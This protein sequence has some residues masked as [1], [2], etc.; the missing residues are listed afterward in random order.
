MKKVLVVVDMQKDFIDGALGTKE[1]VAIV[2]NVAA[3][4]KSFDGEVIFTRDTHGDNYLETQEG[5]NL[6]VPHCIQGTDGWQLDRKLEV[7]RTDSMRLFDKPTF[8]SVALAEYLKAEADLESVTL[9][10]L[11]TDIC[12][13]S[14]ALLIKANLP[15]VEVRVIEQC[16][17]G[18]TPQSHA[19]AIEAMKMC[20]IQ[21][22]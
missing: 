22:V 21:I 20:Q 9:I 19:N 10:G 12:V 3:A 1:A 6:P 16:C 13:I 14:N 7:L 11:C 15:E 17:A 2:D 18:V 5:R 8:G 4:V